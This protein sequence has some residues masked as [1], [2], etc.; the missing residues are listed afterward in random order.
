[1]DM[2]PGHVQLHSDKTLE[3]FHWKDYMPNIK[4]TC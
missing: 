1:M 3:M 2:S 4:N